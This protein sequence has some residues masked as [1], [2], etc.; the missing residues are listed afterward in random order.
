MIYAS[1]GRSASFPQFGDYTVG[2]SG[3]TQAPH[4][5]LLHAYEAGIR[6]DTPRLYLNL[7]YFYQKTTSAIGLYANYLVNQFF[8]SNSGANQY[9]GSIA[10]HLR[11]RS[12]ATVR[13]TTPSI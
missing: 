13:T 11:C 7:D 8:L 12:L 4:A 5:T 9:R 3:T 10:S 1:Y 6:Y 2:A